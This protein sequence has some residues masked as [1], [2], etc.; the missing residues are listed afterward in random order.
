[1]VVLRDFKPPSRP[2]DRI[3]S[4][5][6]VQRITHIYPHFP[7]QNANL[8]NDS[9]N[10]TRIV[11]GCAVDGSARVL[12]TSPACVWASDLIKIEPRNDIFPVTT[13]PDPPRTAPQNHLNSSGFSP[14]QHHHRPIKGHAPQPSLLRA[15]PMIWHIAR[16]PTPTWCPLRAVVPNGPRITDLH[17]IQ[18][19]HVT[20][21]IWPR[22]GVR[23][24]LAMRPS[25]HSLEVQQR[26]RHVLDK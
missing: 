15:R 6:F 10:H 16:L 13:P 8:T 20:D 7:L 26:S 14:A 2:P 11:R 19:V 1:M 4:L 24:A 12:I 9:R 18:D 22:V 17:C 3:C 23:F 5:R 25:L 21:P